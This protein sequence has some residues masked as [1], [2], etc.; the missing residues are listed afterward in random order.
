[1]LRRAQRRLI[2]PTY[3]STLGSMFASGAGQLLLVIS[4][5]CAARILGPENRGQL[6]FFNLVPLILTVLGALGVPV[7][8]TYFI[9]RDRSNARAVLRVAKRLGSAQAISVVCI[10]L[11]ILVIVYHSASPTVKVAAASSLLLGPAKLAQDYGNCILQG[12]RRYAIFNVSRSA[13]S[14]LYA[15]AVVVV[16]IVG[17]GHLLAVTLCFVGAVVAAA[18]FT[19]T[20]ALR[21]VPDGPDS[22]ATTTAGQLL[23]FG[24]RALLGAVYPTEAFQLDQALVGAFL[25]RVAL[26]TYAVGVSFSN[27]PRFIAQSVGLVAYPHV[28]A[29]LDPGEARRKVWRFFWLVVLISAVI[30][31]ILE[32]AAPLLVPLLFGSAFR[33]SVGLTQILLISSFIVSIRRVLSD[34]MRG[35]GY[36]SLGSAG[37]AV[38]LILLLPALGVL[39]PL[40]G[41]TGAAMAMPIAASGGFAALLFGIAR[42]PARRMGVAPSTAEVAQQEVT[43]TAS[44]PG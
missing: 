28:A 8:T 19:L 32:L 36:P 37:E 16:F 26:G 4:G 2:R 42:T 10:H 5:I 7:A 24:L 30:C 29:T 41:L 44:E 40:D 27:L 14:F 9:A 15:T 23:K 12:E 35:A 6:A 21:R 3:L 22:S 25:S 17:G 20:I 1:M 13:P 39:I 34:G 38:G 11:T 18:G 43:A 31:G 33:Q